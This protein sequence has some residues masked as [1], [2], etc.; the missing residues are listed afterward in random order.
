MF[1]ILEKW[2][3]NFVFY[4]FKKYC[5]VQLKELQELIERNFK[6]NARFN[7]LVEME[8]EALIIN[9]PIGTQVILRSNEPEPY[10]IGTVAGFEVVGKNGQLILVVKTDDGKT[11][12]TTDTKPFYYHEE[13]VKALDKLE[14]WEQWNIKSRGLSILTEKDSVRKLANSKGS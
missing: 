10:V 5:S 9:Y 13:L 6:S 4:L 3:S 12:Y 11:V 14:W 1:K 7:L 2:F 8:N